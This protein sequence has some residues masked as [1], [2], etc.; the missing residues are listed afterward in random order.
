MKIFIL[1]ILLTFN[2]Y[3][4]SYDEPDKVS[5]SQSS[6]IL[7]FSLNQYLDYNNY[8]FND[9]VLYSVL[10]ANIPGI[11]KEISDSRDP[12]NHTAEWGDIGAN[13]V[14]TLIGVALSETLNGF[15][16]KYSKN[17]VMVGKEFKF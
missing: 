13:F 9:R 10:G 6:A 2:C 14:G 11:L 1:S 7:A 17:S 15:T 8:D 16:V 5:H 3:G 12:A 4:F